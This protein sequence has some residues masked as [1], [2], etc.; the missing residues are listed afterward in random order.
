MSEEFKEY[1]NYVTTMLFLNAWI[2]LRSRENKRNFIQDP[3]YFNYEK[4]TPVSKHNY[5]SFEQWQLL[6]IESKL[7]HQ[8]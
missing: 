1:F 3:Y 4:Y 5:C 7:Q 8:H 2:E 6:S